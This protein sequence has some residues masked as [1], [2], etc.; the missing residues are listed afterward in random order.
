[1]FSSL[2]SASTRTIA[3]RLSSAA[4]RRAV[5]SHKQ[6]AFAFNIR[7]FSDAA[8]DSTLRGTVKWFDS[9][10]GFG[11]LVPD[12]GSDDVFVHQSSIH[13]EGFRS[14]AVSWLSLGSNGWNSNDDNCWESFHISCLFL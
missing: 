14:L 10:K 7:A 3:A 1:M 2:A 9:K 5:P 11:F 8:D 4:T 6:A 12:D 13:A